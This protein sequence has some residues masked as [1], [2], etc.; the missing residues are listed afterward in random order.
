M[1]LTPTIKETS[2]NSKWFKLRAA[3]YVKNRQRNASSVIG[4][5]NFIGITD[6]LVYKQNNSNST[7]GFRNK[8]KHLN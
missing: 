8:Q 2:F 4:I 1:S 6:I 5:N 7:I 3:R